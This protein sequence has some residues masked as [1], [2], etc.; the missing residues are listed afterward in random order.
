[1]AEV[2]GELSGIGKGL[3]MN[4]LWAFAIIAIVV[5]LYYG[6]RWIMKKVGKQKAFTT[7]AIN[8][9]LNGVIEFDKLAFVKEESS[10]LLE[11]QFQTRK[12]DSIPPI[13]KHLI[14]QSYVILINYA[15][16]HYAV[17]DTSSTVRNFILG[18]GEIVP[19]NLGMKKY[20]TAKQR[21]ILNK[22]EEKKKWWQDKLPYISLVVVIVVVG[23]CA[24]AFLY[25]GIKFE[26]AN[27]A[28]RIAE[29]N[30]AVGR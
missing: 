11:M 5:A 21:E 18:N 28:A 6:T 10:G 29:C 20:I 13:P 22:F 1:M 4:I 26:T 24:W 25:F 9:D 3:L 12:T 30:S 15:P 17:L 23:L 27:M 7:N 8:I 14:K 19:Y 16:G 2:I